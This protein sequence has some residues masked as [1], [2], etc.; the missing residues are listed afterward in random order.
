MP[1]QKGQSGNPGGR[2][3]REWTWQGLLEKVGNE[4]ENKTGQTFKDL[5]AKRLW[6]E[7]VNGNVHAIK[8]L[9]NRLD[10]MPRQPIEHSGP[11]GETLTIE[12][13]EPKKAKHGTD[14][15]GD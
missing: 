2:P 12:F 7:C 14:P 15:T 6:I 11:E 5:V 3:K 8:E 13:I 1:F 10:G 9:F 4:V